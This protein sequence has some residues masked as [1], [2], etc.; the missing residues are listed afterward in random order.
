M[1]KSWYKPANSL[2]ISHVYTPWA[3]LCSHHDNRCNLAS[4]LGRRTS[5]GLAYCTNPCLGT[6]GNSP[7]S[8]SMSLGVRQSMQGTRGDRIFAKESRLTGLHNC[9]LIKVAMEFRKLPY[10]QLGLISTR[11]TRIF[12]GT[13]GIKYKYHCCWL[14]LADCRQ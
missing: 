9:W 5:P 14:F 12:I 3:R 10:I 7:R 11:S 1:V 4:I 6:C 2:V 8:G 13:D